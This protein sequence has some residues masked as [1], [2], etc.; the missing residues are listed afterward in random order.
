[1]N[2][3]RSSVLPRT[4]VLGGLTASC[5]AL[6]V[7]TAHAHVSVQP[8][9]AAKGGYSSVVFKVPNE[10]DDAGT[11]KVEVH[12]PSDRPLASVLTRPVPGWKTEVVRSELDKP[13]D[14]HGKKLTEAVTR[15]TWSG[16]TIEPGSYQ[17][18]PVSIGPLPEDTDRMV[19][20]ALQTYED[21]E[22]VRWIEV[23]QEGGEEPESPAPVLALT[24]A[25]DGHGHGGT[26]DA[27]D[28]PDAPD[29]PDGSK[30]SDAPGK[31]EDSGDGS[32]TAAQEPAADNTARAL[33]AV[34]ILV[35]AAGVA[36]GVLAG[37]RRGSSPSS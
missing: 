28:A 8:G 30:A 37:R 36:F 9:E 18:F 1:M 25:G 27:A 26:D 29:A 17:E 22:V 14:S 2:A 21:G 34:G 19:F 12:F 23:P 16:G 32:G 4:A 3:H 33:G 15:I 31:N 5:L 6:L 11:T 20:K 35:G 24:D 10:R 13:V 7:G